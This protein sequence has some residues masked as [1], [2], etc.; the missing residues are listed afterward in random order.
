MISEIVCDISSCSIWGGF[1]GIVRLQT[2]ISAYTGRCALCSSMTSVQC[3]T[4]GFY[5]QLMLLSMYFH[6][7]QSWMRSRDSGAKGSDV[8]LVACQS[9]QN[10]LF[11]T[12]L[13]L[14]CMKLSCTLCFRMDEKKQRHIAVQGIR[15]CLMAIH[16]KNFH[17]FK[18]VIQCFILSV[19]LSKWC[20]KMCC[21]TTIW[22]Y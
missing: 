8:I 10:V 18:H 3:V 19:R 14:L 9:F 11:C 22:V 4:F 12:G 2:L 20:C 17:H 15:S 21:A 16:C 1:L 7:K 13:S 5:L 6:F